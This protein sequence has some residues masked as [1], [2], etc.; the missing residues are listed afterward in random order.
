MEFRF[1]YGDEIRVK[2]AA[3]S[4]FRP[5]QLAAVCSVRELQGSVLYLIEFGD[6]SDTEISESLIEAPEPK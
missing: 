5:G 2:N 4:Q 1:T 6:G 3:P